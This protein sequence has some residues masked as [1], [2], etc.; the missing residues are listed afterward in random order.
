MPSNKVCCVLN[1]K[2]SGVYSTL[3]FHKFPTKQKVRDAWLHNLNRRNFVVKN[4]VMCGKHFIDGKPTKDHPLPVLHMGHDCELTHALPPEKDADEEEISHRK[5]SAT[6]Q[7]QIRCRQAFSL[8][9]HRMRLFFKGNGISVSVPHAAP[10]CEITYPYQPPDYPLAMSSNPDLDD[11]NDIANLRNKSRTVEPP[12]EMF[13][14]AFA[15]QVNSVNVLKQ[16]ATA[17]QVRQDASVKPPDKVRKG[18]RFLIEKQQLALLF[19]KCHSACCSFIIDDKSLNAKYKNG[20]LTVS[21]ACLGG[22]KGYWR[23]YCLNSI[24]S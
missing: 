10:P 9:D 6:A 4:Q 14:V 1:C 18:R 7:R 5:S 3:S 11:D 16:S 8:P 15:N 19:T 23:N 24:T 20:V 21:Y 22:H 12:D 2:T 13:M 17:P